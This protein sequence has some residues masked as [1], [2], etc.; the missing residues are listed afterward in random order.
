MS[1][2]LPLYRDAKLQFE[3]IYLRRALDIAKGNVSRAARLTG[4][5]RRSLYT[6]MDRA[7]VERPRLPGRPGRG[8]VYRPPPAAKSA[9]SWGLA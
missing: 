7:G 2:E 9:E 1:V 5:N 8:R 3:A 4:M 6:M